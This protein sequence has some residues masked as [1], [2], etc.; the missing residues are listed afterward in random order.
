[1]SID[2][3]C[4]YKYIAYTEVSIQGVTYSGR[5]HFHQACASV[6]IT[7]QLTYLQHTSHLLRPINSSDLLGSAAPSAHIENTRNSILPTTPNP[8][9]ANAIYVAPDWK[10]LESVI[11]YLKKNPQLAQEIAQRS[12]AAVIKKHYLSAAAEMCYWRSLIRGWAS[13]VEVEEVGVEDGGWS[14]ELGTRFETYA[15]KGTGRGR[16]A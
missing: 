2:Q 10:D 11:M 13:A 7:P 14:G 1:M 15:L 6:L 12:R 4:K 3:F 8:H 9:E 16:R 5:L